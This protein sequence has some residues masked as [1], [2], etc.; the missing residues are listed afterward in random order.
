MTLGKNLSML[1]R[2]SLA[3]CSGCMGL[4]VALTMVRWETASDHLPPAIVYLIALSPA[5][6]VAL[7]L[8]IAGRYVAKETDEFIKTTVVHSLL[9]AFGVTLIVDIGIGSLSQ[10]MPSM[11]R[12]VAL[13]SVDLFCI[14]AMIALRVL[15]WRSG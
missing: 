13:V 9:W 6:P 11:G 4:L 8:A 1:Q 14:V 7:I 12:L 3:G 2:R 10:Y 15:L 5:I